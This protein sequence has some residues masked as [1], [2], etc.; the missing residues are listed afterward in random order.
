MMILTPTERTLTPTPRLTV[1]QNAMLTMTLKKR[2]SLTLI[3]TPTTK[4]MPMSTQTTTSI[5]SSKAMTIVSTTE[6]LM[7]SLRLMTTV[8]MTKTLMLR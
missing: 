3:V 2:A 4:E 6:T 8:T 1:S 7:Q 5:Q